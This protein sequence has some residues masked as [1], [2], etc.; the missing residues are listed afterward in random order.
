MSSSSCSSSCCCNG[1]GGDSEVVAMGRRKR[2][3]GLKRFRGKL[4]ALIVD[5][6]IF[7][8]LFFSLG[9]EILQKLIR[10]KKSLIT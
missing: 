1:D 9:L 7:Y 2:T 6:F 5:E 10:K 4:R 3:M 8:F